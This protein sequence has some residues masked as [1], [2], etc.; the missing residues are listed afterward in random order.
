MSESPQDGSVGR[1]GAPRSA[2]GGGPASTDAPADMDAASPAHRTS[3]A[4]WGIPSPV[5]VNRRFAVRVGVKCAAECRLAG[6][7]VVVRGENGAETGRSRLGAAPEP[8]TS[9]VYAT[10]VTLTAPSRAG[11]HAWVAAFDDGPDP[12]PPGDDA[13]HRAE[14]S[15]A[16]TLTL[17]G[18][19]AVAAS[20]NR[21]PAPAH[22]A[23]TAAVGFRT[24]QPPEHRITVMVRDRDTHAPVAAAT[25][26]AGVHGG[27]TDA[28]GRA[29]IEV[30]S[31]RYALHVR[32]AGRTPHTEVAAVSGDVDVDVALARASDPATDDERIWM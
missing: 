29:V 5:V 9:G 12:T 31:G 13:Q 8:G 17:P 32:K 7:T 2:A 26:R 15:D 16:E 14:T 20:P 22:A 30:P 28:D 27:R 11:A 23:A 4:V 19:P 3:V 18:R 6:R 24:V 25:V 1:E 21:A 10:D